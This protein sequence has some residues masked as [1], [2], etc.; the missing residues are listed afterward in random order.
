MGSNIIKTCLIAVEK[1][2]DTGNIFLK[3]TIRLDG[4]ELANELREKQAKTMIKILNNF[5]KLYPRVRSYKQI[6]KPTFN[7]RRTKFNSKINFKTTN[8]G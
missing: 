7:K 4:S 8:K 3:E 5:L 6:G 1:K 2:V